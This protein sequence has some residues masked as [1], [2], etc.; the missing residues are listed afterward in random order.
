MTTSIDEIRDAITNRSGGTPRKDM[1]A[2]DD[3][4]RL[5]P[6]QIVASTLDEAVSAAA[7][8][9][10]D[11]MEDEALAA[12]RPSRESVYTPCRVWT[13]GPGMPQDKIYAGNVYAPLEVGRDGAYHPQ[14]QHDYDILKRA[15][16]ARFWRDNVF[17]DDEVPKC[18]TCGWTCFNY[19]AMHHH[20]QHAHGRPQQ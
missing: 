2:R 6:K 16:G 9:M 14:S 12:L 20:I 17:E 13:A 18:D 1:R 3:R 19:A 11:A 8:A 7:S 15:L 10:V 5:L 4:G